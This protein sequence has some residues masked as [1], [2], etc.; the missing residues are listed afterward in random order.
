MGL[1][2]KAFLFFAVFFVRQICAHLPLTNSAYTWNEKTILGVFKILHVREKIVG[3]I[4]MYLL[5]FVQRCGRLLQ[6]NRT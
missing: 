5:R 2:K 1:I 4:D 6:G 3:S